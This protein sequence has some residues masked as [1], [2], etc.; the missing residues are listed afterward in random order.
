MQNNLIKI[1]KDLYQ[2]DRSIFS[3]GYNQALEYINKKLP[4]KILEVESGINLGTY[5]VREQWI[6]KD[7]WVK[8]KDRKIINCKNNP[9]HLAFNS[10]SFK[11]KLDKKDFIKYLFTDSEM[12]DGIPQVSV[13]DTWGF[14]LTKNQYDKLKDGKYEVFINTDFQQGNIKIG[15][16]FI[17][18]EI[19]K[20]IV[21]FAN[22]DGRQA[23]D[24]LS[25]VAMLID[26]AKK[27]KCKHSLR[28]IFC[29]KEIGSL[30]WAINNNLRDIDFAVSVN[31]IGNDNCLMM[32][33]SFAKSTLVDMAFHMALSNNAVK[34][35]E[36]YRKA[37]FLGSLR[38]DEAVFNDPQINIPTILLTRY[39]YNE[40]N[41]DKDTPEIIKEKRILET[42]DVIQEIIDI[43]ENNWIPQRTIKGQL[44]KQR[45]GANSL[46]PELARRID[47]LWYR[48]D[49]RM[50]VL[51]L[52]LA[53]E[54]DFY[55]V[56]KLMMKLKEADFIKEK[57]DD[58]NLLPL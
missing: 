34:Q 40:Y 39:P 20:E 58:I 22:L 44:D 8:Y 38:G 35:N 45:F 25:G 42:E 37:E 15:E 24:N 2:F 49:G 46:E 55:E 54:L 28:F 52:A 6:I 18:G 17:K 57:E 29:P 1:I 13:N 11:G 27:L 41:T 47:Y 43:L 19:E 56:D 26:F 4:L 12:P 23:N 36:Q 48:V 3:E 53:H 9:L 10:I 32:Q 5:I 33:R 50:S 31:A 51:E 21:F 14:C 7:A 16:H 30:A